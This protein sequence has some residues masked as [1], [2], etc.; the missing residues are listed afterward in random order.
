MVFFDSNQ[1]HQSDFASPQHG[2]GTGDPADSSSGGHQPSSG[3]GPRAGSCGEV[4]GSSRLNLLLSYSG[5]RERDWA[6]HLPALLEPMGVAAIR[7][8]SGREAT[9]ILQTRRVHIAVVDLGLPLEKTARPASATSATGAAATAATPLPRRNEDT[10]GTRLLQLLQRLDA[11]PPTVVVRRPADRAAGHQRTLHEALRAGAF[12]VLD[13]P[14]QLEQILEIM[15]R[16][17]RRHY[18]DCW[19]ATGGRSG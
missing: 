7:V 9:Q 12:A 18:A 13:V 16:I 2:D 3:V 4:A 1:Q 6:D 19:P 11:P 14:V 8:E 10:G 15:R 17:L 5:W